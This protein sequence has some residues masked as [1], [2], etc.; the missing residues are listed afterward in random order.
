[1]GTKGAKMSA[2]EPA[3]NITMADL[4]DWWRDIAASHGVKIK[5]EW[6]MTG[7]DE[8]ALWRFNVKVYRGL[9]VPD[10]L[11]YVEKSLVWPTA[12]HKTVLGAILWLLMT[13]DDDLCA[14]EALKC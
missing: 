12:S 4:G 14:S 3:A 7:L 13:V 2:R 1:M 8:L 9:G 6:Q 10:E 5:V 11:P